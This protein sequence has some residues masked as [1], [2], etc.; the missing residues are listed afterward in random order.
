[1]IFLALGLGYLRNG[2]GSLEGLEAFEDA[3]EAV[4]ETAEQSP[5]GEEAK[6]A[7][8]G[9]EGREGRDGRP[10]GFPAGHGATP[11]GIKMHQTSVVIPGFQL[12]NLCENRWL[13]WWKWVIEDGFSQMESYRDSP[14][15]IDMGLYWG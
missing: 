8:A 4:A 9:R 2:P 1:M 11:A 12:K 6:A 5:S 3:D 10:E 15:N 7:G 13:I 14:Q